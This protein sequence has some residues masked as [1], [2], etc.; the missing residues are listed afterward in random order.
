MWAEVNIVGG[1]LEIEG[2]EEKEDEVVI[3][4]MKIT[5][6]EKSPLKRMFSNK[7]RNSNTI[8]MTTCMILLNE[9]FV[10]DTS[11]KQNPLVFSK[12]KE[13]SLIHI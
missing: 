11:E 5:W 1:T 7:S 4:D 12:S 3:I 2:K 6:T 13:I 8:K 9:L 10:S